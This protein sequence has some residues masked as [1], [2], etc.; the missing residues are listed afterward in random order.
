L[1]RAHAL[2]CTEH[3]AAIIFERAR[4]GLA[5]TPIE[6]EK[7]ASYVL[8]HLCKRYCE[9]GWVQQFH[10]GPIRNNNPRLRREIGADCGCDSIGD[11]SH[12]VPLSRLLGQLDD[13]DQLA[14]TILYNIN[15]ADNYVFATMAGNFQGALTPG[16]V[17]WGAAWW[18]LDQK[19]GIEWHLN[20]LSSLGLLSTFVG[21]LTDSRS[22][23]SFCRH[24]YFRRVLCNLIGQDIERGEIPADDCL[25]GDLIR[26]LCHGNAHAWFPFEK[27]MA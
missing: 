27:G 5:A 11:F 12:A 3:E 6:R 19:E 15:P 24:E 22:F 26:R 9:K 25:V 14:K 8:L 7:Y 20:N 2:P 13:A 23:G 17:Q 4:S 10:L 16:R 1:E 18:F 21:F